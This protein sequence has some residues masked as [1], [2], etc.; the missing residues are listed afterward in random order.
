[1]DQLVLLPAAVGPAVH[2]RSRGA[3]A[4]LRAHRGRRLDQRG[5]AL[6]ACGGDASADPW[7]SM[8]GDPQ[9]SDGVVWG[10]GHAADDARLSPQAMA[11]KASL[12]ASQM[13]MAPC[14]F[15][16]AASS[17]ISSAKYCKESLVLFTAM[18]RRREITSISKTFVTEFSAECGH[19]ARAH[20]SWEVAKE[21][22]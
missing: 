1:M 6:L 15:T 5:R 8:A 14:R 9:W 13:F 22:H 10:V 12:Y 20:I 11:F 17:R 19:L 16:R 7:R 4:R 18:D 2:L 3:Y 21:H